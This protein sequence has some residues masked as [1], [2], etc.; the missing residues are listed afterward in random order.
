MEE[1]AWLLH[2]HPD[3]ARCLV[4][5]TWAWTVGHKPLASEQP[6]LEPLHT[7]FAAEGGS[8]KAL[9]RAL[10]V[11]DAFERAGELAP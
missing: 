2:D 6:A 4:E 10:I 8:M 11:S 9:L 7:T 5:T 3:F 1:L